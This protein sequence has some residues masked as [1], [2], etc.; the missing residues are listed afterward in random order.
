MS[1]IEQQVNTNNPTLLERV[2]DKDVFEKVYK[3][4]RTQLVGTYDVSLLA[5]PGDE[6]ELDLQ[7]K[8]RDL[9]RKLMR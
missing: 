2:I 9:S 1:V 7:A 3:G 5:K 4:V 8:I 6:A